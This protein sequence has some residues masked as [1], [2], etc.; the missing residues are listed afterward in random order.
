MSR[1]DIGFVEPVLITQ[2]QMI[3]FVEPFLG[4]NIGIIFSFKAKAKFKTPCNEEEFC[5][6]HPL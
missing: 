1:T 5:S 3:A 2:F 4:F 6:W